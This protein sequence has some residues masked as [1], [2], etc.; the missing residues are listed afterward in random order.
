[1]TNSFVYALPYVGTS[2]RVLQGPRG[3]FS[4]QVGSGSENAIDFS[5]PVGSKVCAARDGTV[6]AFWQDSDVGGPDPANRLCANYIVVAHEDGTFA[7]YCHLKK[8]GVLVGLGQKV[9]MHDAI[10]LSGNT[11]HSSEPHLH[12]C[13]FCNLDGTNRITIPIKFATP[14]GE[15]E[16]L[17][18]GQTY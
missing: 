6:V 17:R 3:A 13:V 9:K 1:M 2:C 8:N 4:H 14:S 16:S 5:M 12:F 11:G 15:V 18:E 7:E 10:A